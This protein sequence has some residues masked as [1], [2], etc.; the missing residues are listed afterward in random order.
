MQKTHNDTEQRLPPVSGAL[1]AGGKSRRMGRDK[2]LMTVFGEPLYR[3]NL[4]ALQTLCAQVFI[5]G[6]RPDLATED[7]PAFA[8]VHP[9]SSLAGL[10]TALAHA[11]HDVVLVLPCDLPFPSPE[12]LRTLLEA[13]G[14]ADAV[15][16]RH[17]G[18]DE[19][20]IACY[21]R[22]LL[23]LVREQLT[24]GKF[25]LTDLLARLHVRYLTEDEL[26]PCWRRALVNLNRPT[27]M[28]H[29][30]A[31]P[32]AVTFIARSG[33]GK[34]TLVEQVI[35]LLS[36]RGWTVGA[37]KHD[38]HKFEIDH[39]G[40][41]SWR[42]TRA[43]A[44][45]TAISSPDKSAFILRHQLEPGLD[46]LLRPFHGRVDI[47]LTEGFKRSTLPKIEVY[48]TGLGQPLLSRGAWHDDNL[49]AVAADAPMELD[50]PVLDLNRP[51]EVAG[52]VEERF[53]K[54]I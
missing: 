7:C 8:D 3:R 13:L 40:K 5:A 32:P 27:E 46:E 33:T 20:L 10:E 14:D 23:P 45:L 48:R 30:V 51:E 18:G 15:I 39:E 35:R 19:P 22:S 9:G 1:L 49:V 4:K 12:L 2:A 16:P 36:Q 52:F 25:R 41:D 11:E 28:E 44:A 38:A 31:P 37:L 6:D 54:G 17:E 29:L 50:V 42:F 43:G 34:T 47:V 24:T 26:G 53:L 21:R